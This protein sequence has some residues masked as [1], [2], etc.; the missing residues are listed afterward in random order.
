VGFSVNRGDHDI[1]AA[2]VGV[3]QLLVDLRKRR[4]GHSSTPQDEPRAGSARDASEEY[5]IF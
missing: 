5:G 3:T 1:L 2:G 4:E